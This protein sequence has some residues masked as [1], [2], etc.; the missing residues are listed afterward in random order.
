MSGASSPILRTDQWDSICFPVHTKPLKELLPASYSIE[1][2][3]RQKAIVAERKDEFGDP[4]NRIVAIQS[5]GYSLVPNQLIRD[6]V[7][8]NI[9]DY[10]LQIL[11]TKYYEYAI[12]VVLP[13]V[14]LVGQEKIHK[15]I[16]FRNSYNG[17]TK[18]SIQG[19]AAHKKKETAVK[20]SFYRQICKNGMFGW[21]DQ[22]MSME[23]YLVW[24][25]SSEVLRA[26]T[27]TEFVEMDLT[28]AEEM[29]IHSIFSHKGINLELL[30]AYLDK[31]I[32][33]VISYNMN[34]TV[35]IYERMKD[36]KAD[37]EVIHE[38]GR[39]VKVPVELIKSAV[40]RME[41]EQGML[42]STPNAWL[43][44]NGLNYALLHEESSLSLSERY[45]IDEATFHQFAALSLS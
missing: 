35:G 29:V 10:S 2:S 3:D 33:E 13:E 38:I 37:A 8:S 14:I 11:S 45:A 4:S 12:Q 7:E 17:K 30:K 1:A 21:A 22:F 42:D 31:A 41:L 16:M 23:D 9:T 25:T 18:F 44:Y 20:V 26:K 28:K 39:K 6:V 32:H 27:K 24:L 43:A 36:K 5:N 19:R 15:C 34:L 40:Q